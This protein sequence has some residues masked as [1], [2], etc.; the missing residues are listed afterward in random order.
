M[1]RFNFTRWKQAC[2]PSVGNSFYYVELI[3]SSVVQSLEYTS[4]VRK[5]NYYCFTAGN[6]LITLLSYLILQLPILG[7]REAISSYIYLK[8]RRVAGCLTTLLNI[9]AVWV[10]TASSY[11]D[12]PGSNLGSEMKIIMNRQLE[13]T[14]KE[15]VLSLCTDDSCEG[16]VSWSTT[17]P[18]RRSYCRL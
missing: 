12:V 8:G 14:E 11:S 13:Q 4:Q 5:E 6:N 17:I 15:A 9:A 1:V 2:L 7:S 16:P 3:I 10:S 18:A